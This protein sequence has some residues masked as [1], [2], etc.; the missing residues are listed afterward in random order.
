VKHEDGNDEA[1]HFENYTREPIYRVVSSYAERQVA[2]KLAQMQ[3]E[4]LRRTL[5]S[6]SA[7]DATKAYYG[8][9][10]EA[11]AIRSIQNGGEFRMQQ[12]GGDD[13]STLWIDKLDN[14]SII[15]VD[16]AKLTSEIAPYGLYT[17][18]LLLWPSIPNFPTFDCFYYNGNKSVYCL[19]VTVAKEHGLKNSRAKMVKD[20]FD[21]MFTRFGKTAP[22]KYKAVFVVPSLISPDFRREQQFTG[23]GTNPVSCQKD[24][25]EQW[26]IALD[27]RG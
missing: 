27:I 3:H 7:V 24:Y 16:G 26:K 8:A 13:T 18:K 25:F 4:D 22:Q 9:M 17:K 23:T 15:A 14:D 20:Y 19:Q 21:G 6:F 12:L 2:K 1:S 10:F 5:I 11:F